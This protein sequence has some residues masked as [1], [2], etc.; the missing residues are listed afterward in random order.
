MERESERGREESNQRK[1]DSGGEQKIGQGR[2]AYE[3]QAGLGDGQQGK[4]D[5]V[6][7]EGIKEGQRTKPERKY[8]KSNWQTLL[9]VGK[10]SYLLCLGLGAERNVSRCRQSR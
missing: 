7:Q 6:G 10:K 5:G 9:S 3:R 2:N 8:R 1:S 4:M